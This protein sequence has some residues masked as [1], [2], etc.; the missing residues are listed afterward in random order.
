M[1]AQPII[2]PVFTQLLSSFSGTE[3]I[4]IKKKMFYETTEQY[5]K[6]RST[7]AHKYF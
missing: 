4:V 6:E 3:D 1:T 5:I 2:K 7:N